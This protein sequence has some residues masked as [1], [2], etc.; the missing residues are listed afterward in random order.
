MSISFFNVVVGIFCLVVGG[1]F[2]YKGEP[3][4]VVLP[5]IVMGILNLAISVL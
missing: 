3:I 5:N 4:M 2:Y 1:Y